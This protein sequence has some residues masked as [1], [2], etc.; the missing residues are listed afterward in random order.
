MGWLVGMVTGTWMAYAVANPAKHQAHFGGSV[1]HW[2]FFG[3]DFK[4][5]HGL[6][7]LCINLTVVVVM[8]VIL[9]AVHVPKGRDRTTADDYEAVAVP[10]LPTPVGAGATQAT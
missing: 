9:N 4:A 10:D 2:Q 3:W 1:Y 7:A 5:Y 6:I 8:S